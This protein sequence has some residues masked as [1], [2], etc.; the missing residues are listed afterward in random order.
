[1][2]AFPCKFKKRQEFPTHGEWFYPHDDVRLAH[3]SAQLLSR[4]RLF[5][6]PWPVACQAPLP[7]GFPRQEYWSGLPCPPPGDLPDLGI[8]PASPALQVGSLPM[9]LHRR[10][11][12]EGPGSQPQANVSFKCRGSIS[13]VIPPPQASCLLLPSIPPRIL[14]GA[15]RRSVRDICSIPGSG[16]SPGGGNGYPLQYSC[17][18]NP[19]DKG[20]WRATAHRVA[21]SQT[22]LKQLSTHTR[23]IWFS[24]MTQQ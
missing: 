11:W 20:S 24:L 2:P 16:R 12:P 5:V 9:S 3:N 18:E 15:Q 6:T 8:E 13:K 7:M 22:G 14:K 4:V 1:M 23:M 21:K 17:L 19:M 10:F